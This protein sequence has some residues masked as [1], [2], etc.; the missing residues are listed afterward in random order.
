MRSHFWEKPLFW[1]GLL[2]VTFPLN[3][4][5]YG[6]NDYN[7]VAADAVNKRKG[8]FIFGAKES[9]TYLKSSPKKIALVLLPFIVFFSIV[10]GFKML[11]LLL[12]MIVVNIIY[13]FKPLRIKERPPFEIAIQIGYVLTALFSIWLNGSEMLPWQTFLYLTLFAFQAHIAGEIMDI[14]PDK[15]ANKKTTATILGRRKTKFL[16]F[17][18]LLFEVYILVFWFHDYVLSGFLACFSA[19]LILDVFVIFKSKPYTLPQM[20]LF[21]FAMNLSAILSMIWVLYSGNLLHPIF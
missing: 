1:V 8:N 14:E 19:W 17:S 6:L 7:D 5:V 20:K 3:Y 16:M 4:L 21:G 11:I 15:L 18:L 10:S 9:Y 13:N 12:V 2:F